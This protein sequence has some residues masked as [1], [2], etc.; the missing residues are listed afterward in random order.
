LAILPRLEF[1]FCCLHCN[2]LIKTLLL[3]I[4]RSDPSKIVF[5]KPKPLELTVGGKLLIEVEVFAAQGNRLRGTEVKWCPD[6]ADDD[7]FV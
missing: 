6:Y 3:P 2:D 4:Q 7:T 5:L 1:L